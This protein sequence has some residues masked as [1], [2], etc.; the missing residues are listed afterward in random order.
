MLLF[1]IPTAN[2]IANALDEESCLA[3]LNEVFV[4]REHDESFDVCRT[5]L[6]GQRA[7]FLGALTDVV[8][9]SDMALLIATRYIEQKSRWIQWNLV[10]NYRMLM[11]GTFDAELACR[12]SVLSNLLGRIEPFIDE[13]SL[14]RINE[15]LNEPILASSAK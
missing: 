15:L 9:E 10:L 1:M 3:S 2:D 14:A 11:S 12:A 13:A 4:G 7:E 6:D 5:L 8:D